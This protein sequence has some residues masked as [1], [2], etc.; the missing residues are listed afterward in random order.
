M[1]FRQSLE[2]ILYLYLRVTSQERCIN[3]ERGKMTE[4]DENWRGGIPPR[5][6]TIYHSGWGLGGPGWDFWDFF[7]IATFL[8]GI[9][10]TAIARKRVE[11]GP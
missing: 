7:E 3:G 11:V 8:G 1:Y 2:N 6:D 9:F 5:G 10:Q 4:L